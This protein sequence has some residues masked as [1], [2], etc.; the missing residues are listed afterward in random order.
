MASPESIHQLLAV[1]ARLL[2]QAATEIRDGALEPVQDNI[3]HVGR[4]LVEIFEIEKR[5]FAVRP[6]LTPAYLNE[7]SPTPEANRR[8]TQFMGEACQ[9][10]DA[11]R[12]LEA[13]AKYR[14]Y[15]TME[16]SAHHRG[17]AEHELDRLTREDEPDRE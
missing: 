12:T 10:E 16:D 4:A 9:L 1:A 2:D 13:I 3:K 17:I 8:L 14:E 11:G 6:Q 15:L 7:P 5:I